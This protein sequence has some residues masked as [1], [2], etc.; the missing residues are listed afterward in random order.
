MYGDKNLL[1]HEGNYLAVAR[2]VA[3]DLW[4][5]EILENYIIADT[6]KS[7]AHAKERTIFSSS[8]DLEKIELLKS[9]YQ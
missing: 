7:K 6:E 8:E 2:Q 9:K 4:T 3:R 5:R 1:R